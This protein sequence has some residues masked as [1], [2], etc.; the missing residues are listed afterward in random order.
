MVGGL[1]MKII[2]C[3]TKLNQILYTYSCFSSSLQKAEKSL[4]KH[5]M[6]KQAKFEKVVK[7]TVQPSYIRQE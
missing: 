5:S 7:Y 4:P 1:K 2:A 6:K 3:W